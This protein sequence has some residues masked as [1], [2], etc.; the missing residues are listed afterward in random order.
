MAEVVTQ[1]PGFDFSEVKLGLVTLSGF[2]VPNALPFGGDQQTVLTKFIGKNKRH[3][4]V[5][6]SQPRDIE[7]RGVF[8]YG[9]A[10]ARARFIDSM[11]IAG[12]VILFQW[13]DFLYNVVIKRFWFDPANLFNIPY[14]IALE[15]VEDLTQAQTIQTP[16]Q[17]VV[18]VGL[19]NIIERIQ[20]AVTA[21][22]RVLAAVDAIRRGGL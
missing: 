18:D 14:E 3:V 11:R 6:G 10:V 7:W 2:E 12:D 19:L 17:D 9:S 22:A 13:G 1:A 4:Q 20:D 16:S 21:L 8:L 5:L 15:I